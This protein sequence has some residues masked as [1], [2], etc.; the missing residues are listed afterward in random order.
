MADFK[1]HPGTVCVPKDGFGLPLDRNLIATKNGKGFAPGDTAPTNVTHFMTSC[2]TE[3]TQV[4]PPPGGA[5]NV[6]VTWCGGSSRSC[7]DKIGIDMDACPGVGSGHRVCQV[8]PVVPTWTALRD[9]CYGRA[10]G[11]A[12]G[13]PDTLCP[14]S[15]WC[16]NQSEFMCTN[17]RGD[18]S[19]VVSCDGSGT[20]PTWG[21]LN[22]DL[23]DSLRQLDFPRWKNMMEQLCLGPDGKPNEYTRTSGCI[24]FLRNPQV[25]KYGTKL[26]EWC[27][28]QPI[29]PSDPGTDSSPVDDDLCGC[30]RDPSFYDKYMQALAQKWVIPDGLID[31]RPVCI[32]PNC[33]NA[34]VVD[35]SQ[36]LPGKECK[37]ANIATCMQTVT[38]NAD[39]TINGNISVSQS[40]K[41]GTGIIPRNAGYGTC[42]STSDCVLG[43]V[44]DPITGR[45]SMPNDVTVKCT[46]NDDCATTGG[47]VCGAATSDGSRYCQA[48]PDPSPDGGGGTPGG[49]GGGSGGTGGSAAPA[50]G[51]VALYVVL[52]VVVVAFVAGLVWWFAQRKDNTTAPASVPPPAK[53]AKIT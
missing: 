12:A 33:A 1:G 45:C 53:K 13:C 46:T 5:N 32:Y 15:D 20:G 6:P 11:V 18:R 40:C 52:A 3:C 16:M 7:K 38:V 30:F 41:P 26:N 37:A 35:Q 47:R 23:C 8:F 39:G 22:D 50:S 44:C 17:C 21:M 28:K 2:N 25:Q 36:L 10:N 49:D 31:S 19:G 24:T 43:Q 48:P 51:M 14:G 27:R 9:C 29:V 34:L 4:R 42:K